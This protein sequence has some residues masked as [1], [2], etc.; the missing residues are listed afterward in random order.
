MQ[1]HLE[2]TFRLLKAKNVLTLQKNKE[3][4]ITDFVCTIPD[5]MAKHLSLSIIKKGFIENGTIDS[6]NGLC[7]DLFQMVVGTTHREIPKP[8]MDNLI[9]HMTML[10]AK[11][12]ET[13]YLSDDLLEAA[14]IATDKDVH[15]NVIRRNFAITSKHRQQSK[16]LNH[17]TQILERQRIIDER[18][19][20][21]KQR[22]AVE[23]SSRPEASQVERGLCD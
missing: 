14:G 18:V 6:V 11:Q 2:E 12:M 22:T 17:N 9:R 15:G 3:C 23:D 20:A 13:G 7:P 16:T 5:I 4:T 8:E 1:L 10:F 19:A 21:A